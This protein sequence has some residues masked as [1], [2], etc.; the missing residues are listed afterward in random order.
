[1]GGQPTASVR[2]LTRDEDDVRVLMAKS[3]LE[4]LPSLLMP[5][6]LKM[7][8]LVTLPTEKPPSDPSDS[9]RCMIQGTSATSLGVSDE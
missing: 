9:V 6:V 3:L 5:I 8:G 1:M 4:M 7:R 2:G